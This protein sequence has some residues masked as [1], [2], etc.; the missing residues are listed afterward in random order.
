M[1]ATTCFEMQPACRCAVGM[2]ATVSTQAKFQ[3][4]HWSFV[5]HL[6]PSSTR[7]CQQQPIA[8][9]ASLFIAHCSCTYM[10]CRLELHQLMV[11]LLRL[12]S[13]GSLRARLSPHS[14]SRN[15]RQYRTA[16]QQPLPGSTHAGAPD[17][18]V[19][20]RCAASCW[21]HALAQFAMRRTHGRPVAA[22]NQLVVCPPMWRLQTP[23]C[24][25]SNA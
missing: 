21:L 11:P 15:G 7:A 19:T 22:S 4:R 3:T 20:Q 25:C 9:A 1:L 2:Q 23:S 14:S 16:W 18:Q 12:H 10:P 13:A 8:A 17:S 5:R 24:S 6:T